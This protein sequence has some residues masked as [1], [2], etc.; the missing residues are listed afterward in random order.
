MDRGVKRYILNTYKAQL[1]ALKALQSESGLWHTVLTDPTSYEEVSGS[2]A[3]AAGI[4]KGI[5]TGV[6]DDSYLECAEKAVKAILNNIAPDLSG[7]SGSPHSQPQTP[8]V[9]AGFE[10]VR[11]TRN[12]LSEKIFPIVLFSPA[13][14]RYVVQNGS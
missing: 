6:L 14:C 2:A 1:R 5:R 8:A 13:L 7:G 11:N 12:I 10:T 9:N 4:L 3:V